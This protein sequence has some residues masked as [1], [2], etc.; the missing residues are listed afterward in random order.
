[1]KKVLAYS[2]V[3]QLGFMFIGVGVGAYWAGVF[4]LMTHAFFK[5]C[6]FLGS[7]S[8]IHGM[9]AVEHDEVAVQDMR[10]M[11]GLRRGMPTTALTS[12]TACLAITAAPIPFFAGFW[13]KDEILWKAFGT[14]NTGGVP[15]VLIYAMGLAA[16]LG[17]SFY[18]WRSYY[19][20]FEGPHA[21]EEIKD[22]VHES[23]PAIT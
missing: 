14:E 18:M 21:R 9:H 23:P 2:T 5:A 13:S 1:M 6:L 22:K 11:G 3:R 8:V 20:T 10:N 17:T 12:R 4:H 15:G 7:G 16:A 19:L